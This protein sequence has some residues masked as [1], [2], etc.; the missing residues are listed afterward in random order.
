VLAS[1]VGGVRD[2]L[3]RAPDGDLPGL[4]VPPGDVEALSDG[5]ARWLA[6][7]DLRS[8]LRAAAAGRRTRLAGWPAAEDA[9]EASLNRIVAG[10]V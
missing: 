9:F 2:A 10:P 4:L 8:R 7:G 1:D 6:D 5:L 3:G